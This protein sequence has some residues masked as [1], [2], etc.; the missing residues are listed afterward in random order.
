MKEGGSNRRASSFE[1][2]NTVHPRVSGT[3][4]FL[5]PISIFR[6]Q[7]WLLPLFDAAH[8]FIRVVSISC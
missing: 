1:S 7:P 2:A 6:V 4:V 5:K 8:F 3:H